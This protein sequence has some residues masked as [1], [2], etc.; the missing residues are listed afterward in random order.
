MTF[1]KSNGEAL[2]QSYQAQFGGLNH[3]KGAT[4]GD[5]YDM[6]NMT[7]DH[8]PV[9]SP[10]EKRKHYG[11]GNKVYGLYCY[12]DQMYVAMKVGANMGLYVRQGSTYKRLGVLT[13]GEKQ[14]EVCNMKL[15]IYPD[16]VYYDL[17]AAKAKGTA[18]DKSSLP[19]DGNVYGD[20]Y[21]V[22]NDIYYWDGEWTKLGAVFANMASKYSGEVTFLKY[23]S[24]AVKKDTVAGKKDTAEETEYTESDNAIKAKGAVDFAEY[25]RVNDAVTI[26]GAVNVPDNNKTVVIREIKGDTLYFYENTFQMAYWRYLCTKHDALYAEEAPE[27]PRYYYFFAEGRWNRFTLSD[28]GDFFG[29]IDKDAH[30]LLSKESGEWVL[31]YREYDTSTKP[32]TTID[33]N[34]PFSA[35]EEG[36]IPKDATILTFVGETADTEET[37]TIERVIPDLDYLLTV[38]NR[39]WGAKGD[40]VWGSKLGDPLNWN[41]FEGISTDSY[42]VELG[43][44]GD[45]TGIANYNGYPT[46]FKEDGIYKLYGAYPSAYQMYATSTNGVKRECGKSI[47]KIGDALFYVSKNG[48]MTYA[49]GI[50]TPVGEPL[51]V[52]LQKG[53]GGTD[54]R[55]YYLSAYDG[56]G[57]KLYVYD[58][59]LGLWHIEDN[60]EAVAMSY[61]EELVCADANTAIKVLGVTDDP[62]EGDFDW[63]VVFADGVV[64]SPNKKGVQKAI[65][66]ADCSGGGYCDVYVSFDGNAPIHMGRIENKGKTSHT[67]PIILNRGDHF[68]ISIKGRGVVDIYGLSYSYYHGSEV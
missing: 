63:E 50:P 54:G 68:R 64:G 26:T 3:R 10:R 38:N 1:P 11:G 44:P 51:G 40:T 16:K 20:V 62:M 18:A 7:S 25:F 30:L 15:I 23:S 60:T 14:M 19:A 13:E 57:W 9:L 36:D 65:L 33:H 48:V 8:Y 28:G 56:A 27:I 66:R 17:N 31:S 4:D 39:L 61:G 34:L 67:L 41:C 58:T 29:P 2:K 35:V 47:A 59:Y 55:K 24:F 32:V 49:G 53:I 22:G 46:F 45:V 5:I 21:L 12:G 6:R 42:S 43:S 52:R 37:V